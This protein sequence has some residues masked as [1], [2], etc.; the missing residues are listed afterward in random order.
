MSEQG[1]DIEA[2]GPGSDSGEV[3]VEGG[4]SSDEAGEGPVIMGP[5]GVR[6]DPED[7]ES[8][9]KRTRPARCISPTSRTSC[10]RVAE[11]QAAIEDATLRVQECMQEKGFDVQLSINVGGGPGIATHE[12][13]D[14]DDRRGG[15]PIDPDDIDREALDAA[16]RECNAIFDEYD[17]LDDMPLPGR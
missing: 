15:E 14:E 7:A 2:S 3:V 17:E 9:R 16:T 10:G 8:S 6:I 5:G 4:A 12:D 1:F 11:Q 13:F